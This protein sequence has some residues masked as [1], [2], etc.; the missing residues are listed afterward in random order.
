MADNLKF[1][2]AAAGLNPA[3]QK[4]IDEFNKA[5]QTH[6]ELSNLPADVAQ[7]KYQQLPADQQQSL[8][9]NFGN[10][11][12]ITKP[13]R[14]WLGTAW[15]YTGG[16][17]GNALGYAGSHVLAGLGNVSDFMT[18]AYRT[19]AIAADQGV[20]L[21]TAWT[22]AN[23]KGDKVFSPNA[24]LDAK[25]KYGQDAVDVAMRIASGEK[26][27]AIAASATPNQIKFAQLWDPQNKVV[28]A[29]GDEK[30]TKAAR[31]NFQNTLDAVNAAKY[32]PG[33][34]IANLVT[35]KDL[36]GS[37]LFYK[38]ISGTF[39]A[40]YRVLADPLL[41]AG[42]AKRLY[43]VSK[44]A[45]DV[46]VGGDKAAE[47]FAKPSVQNFWNQYGQKLDNLTKAEAS[48]NAQQIAL[49]K[50][51]LK[52]MAPEFGP[53]VIKAFQKA[54]LPITDSKSAQAFFENAQQVQTMFEG[55]IGRQRVLI[56]RMTPGRMLRIAAATTGNKILNLDL[57]GSKFV[58][59]YFFDGATDAD[60][61]AKVVIDGQE[62]LVNKV[63]AATNFKGI[64]RF[65][66]DYIQYRIDRAKAAFT[67]APLFKD[68]VLDVMAPDAPEKMYRLAVMMLPPKDA[69]LFS[70]AF[71]A[72]E[73]VG[74]RKE[75]YYGL[76][77][78]IAEARGL[79]TTSPG[80][81]ITRQLT[82]K[83]H[84]V[85]SV[86]S[87]SDAFPEVGVIPSDFSN[88]V[89]VPSL[90]DLDRA[91][92]RNGLFQKMMGIANS[93]FANKM[94]SAWSF[95]TLAGPRYALRNAGEDLMVNLA[96][97]ESPWGVAKGRMLSTRLNTVLSGLQKAKETET[98]SANQ[99]GIIMRYVNKKD[100]EKYATEFK[101]LSL[102]IE[103]TK[104]EINGLK[105]QL[106]VATD[107]VAKAEIAD[108]ISNLQKGI[109]GG[110]VRQSREIFAKALTEGRINRLRG[111]LGLKPL[112]QKEA[113]HL[114][115]QIIYGD[116]QNSL[117]VVSEAGMNFATGNDYITRSTN[118]ARQM[119]V[120]VHALDI[121]YPEGKFVK[122]PGERSYKVQA[123]SS[124]DEASMVAWLMRIGYYSNDELGSIAVA[125]MGNRKTAIDKMREWL[126]TSAGKKFLNEARLTTKMDGD[127]M[128][129][130]A[131]KR[132]EE[133]FLMQDGV[134][135]NKELLNKI[136]YR[137]P[138]T[139]EM[140]IGGNLSLD[141][142]P[143]DNTFI[144]RNI[145]G[146]TLIPAV[147]ANQYTSNLVTKGWTW[148]GMSNARMSRQPMVINEM[149]RIRQQM[150]KTG[151][152]NKW[153]ESYTRH[154][155]P[156]DTKKLTAATEQAKKAFAG[157][158]EERAVS[159]VLAYVDNPLIRT[160]IAFS[161]RNFA[162]FYRATEDFYRRMYRVV[163]YNPEGLVKAALTY[164]GITHS[165]WVQKDDNGQDYFV[166][167][168]IGP[169]YNAV[170]NT[171]N[172]LGIGDQFKVPFPVQF[173]AQLKMI[174]P[175]LNPDSLVPTFSGPIAAVPVATVS[176]LL[177]FMGQKGAADTVKGYTMGKYAVDQPFLSMFLPAHI[178]RLYAA[179]NQDERNSQYASAW[180]KG[181]TYL[182]ASGHGLPKK[183][184]KDGNLIPPTTGELEAYRQKIKNTTLTVL[185]L[186]FAFGF[187]APASPQVQLKSDMAQWISD[188]GT[189]SFKQ[190]FAD[191]LNQY[192]NDYDKAMQKWIELFP[193][194]IP[195]TIPESE[196]KSLA[197]I[198]YAKEAGDFVAANKATFSQYPLAAGFLIPHK[199]GFSWDAYRQMKTQGLL[200]N[201]RV[202]DFLRDVQT[203]GDLQTYY[204][205]KNEF[206]T[207]LGQVGSDFERTQLRKDFNDWKSVFLAG[208]PLVQE[209]LSQG[210]QKAVQR[211]KTLDEL[212]Q[213]LA[214]K[215][216]LQPKTEA[217]LSTMV[218]AYNDYQTEKDNLTSANASPQLIRNL[219]DEAIIRLRQL[220]TFNENTQSAYNVIFGRLLGD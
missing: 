18:R 141:D 78:T 203:A 165:G 126:D 15:H 108:K 178:N 55:S 82:G 189:A 176:S 146:P 140:K 5:L 200:Q 7:A 167:P 162:R 201:K 99:L 157:I 50:D 116:I 106:K 68:D 209:E 44:Y 159:Q 186:R 218:K 56:P 114:A 171:L 208:R 30:A 64:G 187:F 48:K 49:A 194:E 120:R 101:N 96:I 196:K 88:F 81:A 149:V 212:Q 135:L 79:H 85:H 143:R 47:V 134:T 190:A 163:K 39:D 161:A 86:N 58:N 210:S 211:L 144:P 57:M 27:G 125:N 188:N 3:Q 21:G 103:N 195:Y 183:Y 160:Q 19:G 84:P 169:V 54:E 53:A 17:V 142:L 31:D 67:K 185:G 36:E 168:G 43:D 132:A 41:I 38:A 60:G 10:E 72:V 130:L 197:V 156:T 29:F 94:T 123:V 121:K 32:S 90:V 91:A 153:I 51:E 20:D 139:G 24:I 40:A 215:P 26:I 98:A 73:E 133:N 23:D 115:E 1:I 35:P 213:L 87:A 71:G 154:I 100:A 111:S 62:E 105:E 93:N 110:V 206:E 191:L 150:E 92:A 217:A 33:R 77:K 184:D 76:W 179:M 205:K 214:S 14:G 118:L 122:K 170:Q 198:R 25:A 177:G 137:D 97:G 69:R 107:D 52:I 148:L 199:S 45:V 182:E 83:L 127:A 129:N 219:K 113:E 145:V 216:N 180:R 192:P 158:V 9:K 102:N 42:K 112:N 104:T 12:P 181:V 46:V 13:K 4:Q 70:E 119:G 151:F 166:Y 173:G 66:T 124:Q 34:Q 117:D 8:V 193:N 164:E 138:N 80:E 109:Q 220:A 207:N 61:I 175:S 147:E 37:G 28:P 136:R 59:N 155:D 172:R 63:N 131:Y 11:D 95:L 75:M 74:K 22:L 2:G 16:A 6:R 65:S 152:Y 128:I 204:D 174:T 89:S 202:D